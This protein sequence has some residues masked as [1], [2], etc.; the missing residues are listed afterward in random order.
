AS[1]EGLSS[2]S[3]PDHPP[4]A[5]APRSSRAGAATRR[6][7]LREARRAARGART[8][9]LPRGTGALARGRA[10]LT[11]G[12]LTRR[13]RAHGATTA[14]PPATTAPRGTTLRDKLTSR[15]R[16]A[17]GLLGDGG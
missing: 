13:A 6:G 10:T 15:A 17:R 5:P 9:G 3:S 8:S 4:T 12:V 7:P 2:R 16:A 14:T 1:P 11:R